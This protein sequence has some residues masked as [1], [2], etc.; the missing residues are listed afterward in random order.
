MSLKANLNL[1]RIKII[2]YT[3]IAMVFVSLSLAGFFFYQWKEIKK[4]PNREIEVSTEN[5][6]ERVGKLM[7]LPQDEDPTIATVSDLD[8]LKDQPFFA[9]AKLGYKVLIYTKSRKIIL[10]DPNEDRIVDVAPLSS[11]E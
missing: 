4:D 1:K 11:E 8:A 7:I 9:Q 2:W 3:M 5:L 10:Y 6:L